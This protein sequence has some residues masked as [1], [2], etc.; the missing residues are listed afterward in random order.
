M[1]MNTESDSHL[2]SALVAA[3]LAIGPIDTDRLVSVIT[4]E[5]ERVFPFSGSEL[6]DADAPSGCTFDTLSGYNQRH[7]ALAGKLSRAQRGCWAS[8]SQRL[9]TGDTFTDILMADG[10]GRYVVVSSAAHVSER[11]ART[12]IITDEVCE[13]RRVYRRE[14][15]LRQSQ[16]ALASN[17]WGVGTVL[18]NASVGGKAYREVKI[19]VV[20]ADGTVVLDGIRRG[21]RTQEQIQCHPTEIATAL[22]SA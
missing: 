14:L 4:P 7:D 11:D 13:A 2:K 9:P 6:A 19:N 15:Y 22:V 21:G 5:W 17:G 8:I 18:K 16:V 20:Q 3:H 10:E 1:T 12:K